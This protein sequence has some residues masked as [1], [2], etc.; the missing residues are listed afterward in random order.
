MA[1]PALPIALGALVSKNKILLIKRTKGD[2]V[3]MWCMPGGKIEKKEHLSESAPREIFEE[4]GV[5]VNEVAGEDIPSATPAP[6]PTI[7][8]PPTLDQYGG[9]KQAYL[10]A[11]KEYNP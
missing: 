2:Y 1:D 8:A 6:V 9:D 4:L 10:K 3:G 11:L 7:Q 5:D